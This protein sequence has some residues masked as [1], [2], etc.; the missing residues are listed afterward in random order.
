MLIAIAGSAFLGLTLALFFRVYVL[1]PTCAVLIVLVFSNSFQP[2]QSLVGAVIMMA[3]LITSLQVGYFT[4]LI[5]K[6]F[7]RAPLRVKRGALEGRPI[8]SAAALSPRSIRHRRIR[9]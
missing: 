8:S 1:W 4:G 5:L 6:M 3:A 2:A 7:P 9:H